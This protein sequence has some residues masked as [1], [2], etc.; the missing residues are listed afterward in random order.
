MPISR[1]KH[2]FVHTATMIFVE[3]KRPPKS[4]SN[5]QEF[6]TRKISK[7]INIQRD[8]NKVKGGKIKNI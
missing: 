5:K 2:R 7:T 1:A 4:N 6:D 3:D 8:F